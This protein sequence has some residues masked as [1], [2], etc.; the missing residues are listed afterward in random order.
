VFIDKLKVKREDCYLMIQELVNMAMEKK[1]H[2]I[3]VLFE[4]L[5]RYKKVKFISLGMLKH[6]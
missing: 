6:S 5:S 1:F 3:T 2:Q 4:Q